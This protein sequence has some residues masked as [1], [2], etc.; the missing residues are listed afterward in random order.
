MGRLRLIALDTVNPH[1]G[2]QGSLDETQFAWLCDE[3][4]AAADR[5][6]VI[7]SHH[8]SFTLTNDYAPDGRRAR[9][10]WGPT[11]W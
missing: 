6:V 2:W 9:G 11:S 1:G 3:L 5:H 7:A 8:P 10:C 4:D